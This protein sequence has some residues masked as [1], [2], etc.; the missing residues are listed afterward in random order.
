MTVQQCVSR[1]PWQ[2]TSCAEELH[3]PGHN[4]RVPGLLIDRRSE[5]EPSD[6]VTGHTGYVY[7][8][9]FSPNGRTLAVGCSDGIVALWDC[10]TGRKIRTFNL[11]EGAVGTTGNYIYSVAF[12][13]DGRYLAT[14][15]YRT[16]TRIWLVGEKAEVTPKEVR[17]LLVKLTAFERDHGRTE[18]ARSVAGTIGI[19]R[20]AANR[21]H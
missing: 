21:S 16:G 4:Q 17:L 13:P 15:G 20:A 12:S 1:L 19:I 2:T 11:Q 7:S 6:R 14:G 3:V 9:A 8:V 5:H 18:F 10:S